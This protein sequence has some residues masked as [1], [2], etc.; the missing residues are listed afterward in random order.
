MDGTH[1]ETDFDVIVA[2]AGFSGIY[3]LH[4]LRNEL[5]LRVRVFEVGG[6]VGGTWYWNRYPGALSDSES[7]VY[8]FSFDKE[9]LQSW[10]WR[11][12]YLR[13]PEVLRYLESVVER[14]DLARDI[15]LNTGIKSAIF[16]DARQVW[17]IGT[18]D[19]KT[20]TATYFISGMGVLSS[21]NVPDIPGMDRFQGELHHS[22][23]WP[24]HYDFR[25]KR[26]GVVGT[27]ST[28]IQIITAISSQVK[29]LTVFQRSPQYSVP[30]GDRLLTDDE[31][32]A[33]RANYD[34]IWDDVFQSAVA[35]GFK[36]STVSAMSV[37]EEER[38]RV[39]QDAW[40]KGGGF[41]FMF[42]TFNDIATN[43]E[44]NEAA[45]KFVR[46]KI[47]EIVKDPEKA[48]KLTPYDL[49]AK[50][51]LC[52]TGYFDCYNRDN[53]DVVD[54]KENPI[55][56][57]TA[58][59]VRLQDGTEHELDV[60]VFATGFDALDGNFVKIDIRG[61]GGLTIKEAWKDGPIGYL[62]VA[63]AG[64][65]NMFT[66]LGPNGP[67]TNIP[68]VIEVEVNFVTEFIKEIRRRKV[69]VV[70]VDQ[71]AE[72]EWKGVC[73]A[74]A[75]MTV[76]SKLGSWIFGANIPGKKVAVRFYLGGIGNF[77]Q[78]LEEVAK[79]DYAGF[80]LHGSR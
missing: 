78:K 20:F 22:A 33:I 13:Q 28:G 67:F 12:R 9:L 35:M 16:D 64:F 2:G 57:M 27:G 55:A 31:L 61:R 23:Q 29:S 51:P 8:R 36:E 40:E 48:R 60:L 44:A 59:G 62:G 80:I 32:A 38:Q 42:G 17:K 70:E 14:H 18:T 49:Y 15:Q 53:V 63:M 34:N 54:I 47:K 6:G 4:K 79:N 24:E 5:N 11:N 58:K 73:E 56:E 25:N 45:A 10:E 71:N 52:D 3:L 30:T 37:S 21:T 43:P 77:L 19:N 65:P 74:I 72:H 46:S 1:P 39:F 41:R 26:V 68:P 50:R 76:F 69:S 7:F 75:N 66:I